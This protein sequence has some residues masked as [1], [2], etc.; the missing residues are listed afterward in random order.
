MNKKG[1]VLNYNVLKKLVA[2]YPEARIIVLAEDE[3]IDKNEC[4]N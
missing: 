4:I 2:L 3:T 1:I